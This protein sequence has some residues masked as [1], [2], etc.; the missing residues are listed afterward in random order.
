MDAVRT[1]ELDIGTLIAGRYRVQ[2][3]LGIGGMSRVYHAVDESLGRDVAVKVFATA[4]GDGSDAGRRHDEVTMLAGLSH[5]ALVVL[6]DAA[7]DADP[8]YLTMEYVIGE[9]LTERIRRGPMPAPEAEPLGIAIADALAFVH[10]RGI[11]HRDVKPGNIL[12]PSSSTA[13]GSPA[14]LTDFG[15]ARLIDAGRLTATG[16]VLGTAAYISPEQ[17]SGGI[18]GPP[19]DVYALGLV[20]IEAL[21]GAHPFPG[22]A[23]ES[24]AARLARPPDLESPALAPYRSLLQRMTAVSPRDRPT[25]SEVA[26][27]LGGEA[28]TRTMTPVDATTQNFEAKAAASVARSPERAPL[29]R[30]RRMMLIAVAALVALVLVAATGFVITRLAAAPTPYPEVPGTLGTHLEQLQE[31]VEGTGLEDSVLAASLA[32]SEGDYDRTDELLQ[33]IATLTQQELAAGDLEAE[34]AAQIEAAITAAR[35]DI[36]ALLPPPAV[37]TPSEDGGNGA[38]DNPGGA[39]PKEKKE[40]K[41][42]K[43]GKGGRK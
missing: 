33:V 15:I 32:A 3:L 25:A 5:P 12:L 16:T 34:N 26:A 8:P 24:A 20:L 31:A 1:A 2:E 6:F 11:V 43:D 19:S 17:A 37:D 18:A 10:E 41:E 40:P 30:R 39:E 4:V 35:A 14:K 28:R 7:L 21:T 22:T 36:A 38:G 27:D 9:T 29:D 23:L 42:P 13:T